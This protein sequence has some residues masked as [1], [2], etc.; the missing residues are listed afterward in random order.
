MIASRAANAAIPRASSFV[1]Y[2]P[3]FS[4]TR[5]SAWAGL[6]LFIS[7]SRP[8]SERLAAMRTLLDRRYFRALPI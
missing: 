8:T 1:T 4:L 6:G 2:F 7:I 5:K 3:F